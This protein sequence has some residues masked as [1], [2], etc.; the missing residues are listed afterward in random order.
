MNKI[1]QGNQVL[2]TEESLRNFLARQEYYMKSRQE[3]LRDKKSYS[4]ENVRSLLF[5]PQINEV[6][7]LLA[8]CTSESQL[9]ANVYERLTYSRHLRNSERKHNVYYRTTISDQDQLE[10]HMP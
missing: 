8:N 4:Y 1:P 2:L 9:F 10:S 6:N 5:E 3:R 7:K